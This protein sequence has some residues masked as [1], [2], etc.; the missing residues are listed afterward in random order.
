MSSFFKR[1]QIRDGSVFGDASDRV[2]LR[3]GGVR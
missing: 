2:A 1:I 3:D